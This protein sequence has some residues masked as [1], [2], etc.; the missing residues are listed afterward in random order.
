M[1]PLNKNLQD[2]SKN[3]KK[4]VS[5][6]KEILQMKPELESSIRSSV[7][8]FMNRNL[9]NEKEH[10]K[11]PSLQ[12][13]FKNFRPIIDKSITSL[14]SCSEHIKINNITSM[15]DDIRK[16][17]SLKHKEDENSRKWDYLKML[18]LKKSEL[19]DDMI[20]NNE[21]TTDEIKHSDIISEDESQNLVSIHTIDIQYIH[22]STSTSTSSTDS[23]R[24]QQFFLKNYHLSTGISEEATSNID[25][26]TA[27]HNV[28]SD[29]ESELTNMMY[30]MNQC[31][32][33]QT[34]ETDEFTDFIMN[35]FILFDDLSDENI[36]FDNEDLITFI[37]THLMRDISKLA[38]ND[39]VTELFIKEK[40]KKKYNIKQLNIRKN[41]SDRNFAED[42]FHEIDANDNQIS[43]NLKNIIPVNSLELLITKYDDYDKFKES[44]RNVAINPYI[45]SSTLSIQ[46]ILRFIR[47]VIFKLI[48]SISPI[49]EESDTEFYEHILEILTQ[50]DDEQ[51]DMFNIV[52]KV[53]FDTLKKLKTHC[54]SYETYNTDYKSYIDEYRE[55]DKLEKFNRKDKMSNEERLLYNN[56]QSIGY[57]PEKD[58]F[59]SLYIPNDNGNDTDVIDGS[60]NVN[61]HHTI[62]ESADVVDGAYRES[63]EGENSDD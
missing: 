23:N 42:S 20:H 16:H 40:K 26:V 57:N 11:T 56:L 54:V 5:V 12:D 49:Y 58:E 28:R 1:Y 8:L 31:L 15:Y 50:I 60:S 61:T 2:A 38:N 44:S 43:N 4:L 9:L 18:Q 62:P 39:V 59:D 21:F 41:I 30:F 25:S 32:R 10:R 27:W 33:L 14:S 47:H 45:Q 6:I 17:G 34:R 55:K 48:H 13:I 29:N 22:Q 53:V 3:Q 63:Y 19:I 52:V 7:D 46:V 24:F 51:R 36:R 35:T 37:K